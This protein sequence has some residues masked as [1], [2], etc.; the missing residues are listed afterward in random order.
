MGSILESW[1]YPVLDVDKLGHEV[2]EIEKSALISRFGS[3]ILRPEGTIDRRILGAT[4][5]GNPQA[6][7]DLEGIVHPTANVMTLR[8]VDAQNADAAVINAALL[9]RSSV[10]S[11][12]DGIILV[13]APLLIRLLRAKKRDRLPWVAL[14]QRFR[15]QREFTSQ[16]LRSNTDIYPV[17][18]RG[19]S[20]ACSDFWRRNLEKQ[21][22]KIEEKMGM[23]GNHRGI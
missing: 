9:H 18:N 5:F 12:L 7:A 2:I 22:R 11:Q 21:L 4:V 3:D 14:F 20:V 1:G 23:A 19:F 16:Y 17:Y 13:Q 15:S 10:F 6:L 8:W